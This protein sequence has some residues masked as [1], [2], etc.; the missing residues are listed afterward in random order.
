MS[1]KCKPVLRTGLKR[2]RDHFR[3]FV[4]GTM[5]D[6]SQKKYLKFKAKYE[7]YKDKSRK[8]TKRLNEERRKLNETRKVL[9]VACEIITVMENKDKK[10]YNCE[11]GRKNKYRIEHFFSKVVSLKNKY[12]L[13][14]R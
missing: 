9:N 11:C 14:G 10:I 6:K 2:I 8:L 3:I 1:T 12:N 5:Y 13:W 4:S 7:K